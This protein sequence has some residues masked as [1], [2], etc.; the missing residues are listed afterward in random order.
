MEDFKK[1]RDLM[2][3]AQ[4]IPRG[5]K[6]ERVLSAMRKVPRHIFV[7]DY[8]QH[9]AYADMALPIGDEQTISQP[10][11]VAIMTELLE[12]KGNE[13]VLEIGTGS[14]YQAAILGELS[15]EVFTIERKALLAKKA[16]ERF[17]ALGYINIYAITG[18]GTLGLPEKSPFDR[19]LITAGSPK[20][21]EPL[22]EQLADGGIII[23]PVGI[24]FSQQLLIVRKSKEGVSEQTH[25]PCVFVPLIG[26]HGWPEDEDS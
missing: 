25:V 9:N 26:K 15:R 10:Y 2:V 21:P 13:K 11:M 7:D 23:A 17:Q 8:M 24:R 14:G 12:L 6:D 1:L 19:I 18:D 3:D 20:I 5:I 16:E 22:I 4:L